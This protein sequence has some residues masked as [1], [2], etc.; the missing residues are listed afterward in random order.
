MF[1]K[2][3]AIIAIVISSMCNSLVINSVP[4]V[5]IVP[6]TN[7]LIIANTN[8]AMMFPIIIFLLGFFG[9]IIFRNIPDVSLDANVPLMLPLISNRPG[10][11]ISI[12]GIRNILSI[13]VARIVPA[14]MPP[15][16]EI[17]WEAIIS[18]KLLSIIF[19]FMF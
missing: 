15:P 16:T 6:N 4:I 9:F 17:A 11:K 12:P 13:W 14:M 7:E 2:K 5:A 3:L 10:T 1:A 8:V 19:S 18:I